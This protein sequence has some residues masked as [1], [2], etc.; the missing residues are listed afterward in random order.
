[1]NKRFAAG[2]GAVAALVAA[3]AL[4]SAHPLRA[5]DHQDSPVTVARPGA[6]ITDPYIFP[7]PNDPNNVVLVMNVH[8][9]IP[10]GQGLTTYFDPQVVYQLNFDTKSENAQTPSSTIA[11]NEVIQFTFGSPG[12]NQQVTVYGPAA[13]PTT[14][15]TTTLVAASGSGTINTPFTAGQMHVF[16]GAREDPFFFDL[17]QF[18]KILPDRAGGST[19]QSCLPQPLG[20]NG[21]CPQGFNN[22]GGDTLKGYNVLSMVV[23]LPRSVLEAGN[24]PKIAYWV[25]T[26]TSSGQ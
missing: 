7:S 21:T 19:A 23:E 17:A 6:D 12:P 10:S 22:P 11:R 14:D 2:A 15:A 24:G 1:M 5:S 20:G 16:A 9:L 4:Y 3:A 25:T 18:L 13:A 26:H 8:P